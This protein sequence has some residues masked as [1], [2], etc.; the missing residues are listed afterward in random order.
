VDTFDVLAAPQRRRIL[1]ELARAAS[2][3][4]QLASALELNQPTISKHLK[5]LRESGFV[6]VRGDAQQRIY[7][8]QAQPFAELDAWLE[9]YRRL[10]TRHLD[11]LERHLDAQTTATNARSPKPKEKRHDRKQIRARTARRRARPSRS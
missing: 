9:P 5:V 3:V 11:A 7:Q 8:L 2:N 10:W 6:S 4:N 1:A